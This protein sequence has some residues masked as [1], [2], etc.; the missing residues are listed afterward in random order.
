MQKSEVMDLFPE[1]I[2]IGETMVLFEAAAD[3]P[4]QYIHQFNKKCGGAESNVAIGVTRL[5]HSAGF[6]SQVGDEEFGKFVIS[7][8][9]GEGVDTSRVKI[10]EDFS[11]GLYIK[12]TLREGSNQVYYYRKGSAASQMKKEELDWEYLR[13][14]K[15]I[16]LTGITPFLSDSCEELIYAVAEFAKENNILL[17]FDPNIRYK[18]MSDK[19][20]AKDIVL[21]IAKLADLVMP[22]I[23]EAEYLLGTRDYN[24]IA[25]YFLNAGV[26]KIAI[27]NGDIGTYYDSKE[28]EA[29]FIPS[30]KVDRVVDPIGA[31]DGFAAGLLSG[32]LEG[33]SLK[34]A[35][36]MG[37]TIGAMV[38]TVKGDVEGLPR[39]EALE[40]FHRKSVDVLR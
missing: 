13:Q 12:E 2:T 40:N 8:I 19:P 14:A 31:G 37:S 34:E 15:V 18:L 21:K 38:V 28:D 22:G 1:L 10:N 3:G 35:V 27:K 26:S 32:L 7:S 16:H 20:D 33:K 30:I 23:D 36:T 25:Q 24:E 29:G 11:T 6:I 9:R 5:G 4:L 39:R 17:S